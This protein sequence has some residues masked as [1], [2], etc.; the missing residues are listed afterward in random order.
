MTAH[1][2]N[3]HHVIVTLTITFV[4][5]GLNY[6]FS[7]LSFREVVAAWRR[8]KMSK[9]KKRAMIESDSDDSGSSD[10]DQVCMRDRW[11]GGGGGDTVQ[12][13]HTLPDYGY[14]EGG[15]AV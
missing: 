6:S 14:C 4:C 9:T 7:V 15:V 13:H 1:D 2:E 12:T 5:K 11:M 3:T 10:V 8:E